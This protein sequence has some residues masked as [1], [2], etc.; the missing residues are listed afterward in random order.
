MRFPLFLSPSNDCTASSLFFSSLLAF[1]RLAFCNSVTYSASTE[2]SGGS[3]LFV[4][5]RDSR[6]TAMRD[7]NYTFIFLVP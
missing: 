1:E 6:L 7:F 2:F 4:N 5:R 3:A